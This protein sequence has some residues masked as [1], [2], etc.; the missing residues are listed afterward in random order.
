MPCKLS[1]TIF[2][3]VET[4][5]MVSSGITVIK[6]KKR[7]KKKLLGGKYLPQTNYAVQRKA[8]SANN[9]KLAFDVEPARLNIMV[10]VT[11][12]KALAFVLFTELSVNLTFRSP[13][14][15]ASCRSH[16]GC[17]LQSY[18]NPF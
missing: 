3:D 12:Y 8:R 10:E 15:R 14:E 7:N 9:C 17:G 5:V 18:R 13:T 11:F 2:Y 16:E 1:T 6:E 4:T